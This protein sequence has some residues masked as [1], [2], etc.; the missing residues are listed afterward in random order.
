MDPSCPT[1]HLS[2]CL[3]FSTNESV[4][5]IKFGG[6]HVV[7]IML[8]NT[9]LG[10]ATSIFGAIFSGSRFRFLGNFHVPRLVS[11]KQFEEIWE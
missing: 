10:L 4:F 1:V 9:F 3:F 2:S 8:Q 7:S 5:W 11:S 6:L